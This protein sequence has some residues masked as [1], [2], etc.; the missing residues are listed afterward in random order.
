M[1][2]AYQKYLAEIEKQQEVLAGI[3][4]VVMDVFAME[5]AWLR[6]Q[7][8]AAQG[9]GAQAADMCAVL[10]RDSMAH[11]ETSART[12]LAA[13]SEGDALRTNLLA[14]RRF[15]KFEPVD[16]IALRRRIAGRL[17][18]TERYSVRGGSGREPA[19]FKINTNP[20][21]DSQSRPAC[22]HCGSPAQ[23]L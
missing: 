5:S 23:S 10:L 15:T 4:D 2:V 19:L 14:L 12:V 7:K 6:T 16:S 21:S 20:R 1:G 8:L 18:E 17:I 9:K 22:P 3:T 13:C 11:I